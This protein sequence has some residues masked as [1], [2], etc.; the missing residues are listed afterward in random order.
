MQPNEIP[1]FGQADPT[2]SREPGNWMSRYSNSE[3]KKAIRFEFIYLISL[4]IIAPAVILILWLELPKGWFNIPEEKFYSLFK[5]GLAWAAGTMG[6]TL[7]DIKWFYHVIARNIW[8]MD[9]RYWR[10]LTPHISGCLAFSMTVLITSGVI[11][12]F[13]S[14]SMNNHA[15]L[16][17]FG[18]LVGYFSDSAIAKLHEIAETL[19]GTSRSK[20]KHKDS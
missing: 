14:D 3:A 12:I 13:D 20:E 1:S 6:G 11:K 7:F 18:F 9:R 19:F 4:F 15:M 2:D 5:Y 16:V 17:G 8:N 10:I